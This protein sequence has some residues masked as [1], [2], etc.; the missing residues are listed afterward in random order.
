MVRTIRTN[1]TILTV[2]D[3]MG[4]VIRLIEGSEKAW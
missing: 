1:R 2:R 4:I 3:A